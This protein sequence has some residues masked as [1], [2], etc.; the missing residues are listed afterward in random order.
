MPSRC[1]ASCSASSRGRRDLHV[2]AHAVVIAG[3]DRDLAEPLALDPTRGFA[4]RPAGRAGRVPTPHLASLGEHHT[5]VVD[6]AA[7]VLLAGS[8]KHVVDP[9]I[10]IERAQ[11]PG[12]AVLARPR[13]ALGGAIARAGLA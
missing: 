1:A 4:P 9:A 2:G 6:R 12:E 7:A 11:R 13:D 10:E 5:A 3:A 8:D